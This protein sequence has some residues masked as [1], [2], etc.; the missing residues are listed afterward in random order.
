M[1]DNKSNNRLDH[2]LEWCKKHKIESDRLDLFNQ[3]RKKKKKKLKIS[4]GPRV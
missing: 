3:E 2:A 4:S 1:V